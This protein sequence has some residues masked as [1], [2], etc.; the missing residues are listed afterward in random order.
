LHHERS[1]TK[2]VHLPRGFGI[3][4][5]QNQG[6]SILFS[7]PQYKAERLLTPVVLLCFAIAT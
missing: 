5:C 4:P 7:C 2:Y 6:T 3:T 1:N